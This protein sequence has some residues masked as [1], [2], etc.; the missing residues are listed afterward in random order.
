MESIASWQSNCVLGMKIRNFDNKTFFRFIAGGIIN[1]AF[2]YCLFLIFN[3][4]L[5]YQFAYFFAYA[6]GV[7]F[8]YI[9]NASAVFSVQLS[10]RAAAVWPLVYILQYGASALLLGAFVENFGIPAQTGPLVVAAVMVPFTFVVSWFVL[11][12]TNTKRMRNN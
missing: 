12:Y 9:Y 2:T 4:V 1:T 3:L 10:F 6:A 8:S 5:Y 7:I 11:H